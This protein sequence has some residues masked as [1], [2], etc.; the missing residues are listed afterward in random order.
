MKRKYSKASREYSRLEGAVDVVSRRMVDRAF[1]IRPPLR[2]RDPEGHETATAEKR[3]LEEEARAF[4]KRK[5]PATKLAD[6]ASHAA[7]D[8]ADKMFDQ[9]SNILSAILADVLL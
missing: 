1:R 5:L 6:N 3:R 2:F 8:V 4:R 9:A 7:P